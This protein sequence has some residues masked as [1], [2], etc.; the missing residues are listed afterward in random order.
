MRKSFF[1]KN[2]SFIIT[3]QVQK[4]LPKKPNNVSI[5]TQEDLQWKVHLQEAISL[6]EWWAKQNPQLQPKF[7]NI[8]TQ[9]CIL[10][11]TKYTWGNK[12]F[13][14]ELYETANITIK[15][16]RK[17]SF[18]PSLPNDLLEFSL[19]FSYFWMVCIS[20]LAGTWWAEMA[21][22]T[23]KAGHIIE[24]P[25]CQ[26]SRLWYNSAHFNISWK[27]CNDAGHWRSQRWWCLSAQKGNSYHSSYFFFIEF[28]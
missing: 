2:N 12:E 20:C 3:F 26:V 18:S 9:T 4:P 17:H 16:E 25:F 27:H 8:S 23:H 6:H 15:Q 13:I 11:Y 14:S 7:E 22:F 21:I 1:V 28:W 10:L 5:A 24:L 19:R